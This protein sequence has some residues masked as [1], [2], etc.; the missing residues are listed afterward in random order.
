MTYFQITLQSQ[1]TLSGTDSLML[2]KQFKLLH[3]CKVHRNNASIVTKKT[4]VYTY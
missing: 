2:N 4:H 1:G 3:M